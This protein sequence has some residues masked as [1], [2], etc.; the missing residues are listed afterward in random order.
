MRIDPG[1]ALTN[2]FLIIGDAADEQAGESLPNRRTICY[3]FFCRS[4]AQSF[5]SGTFGEVQEG[6]CA[7]GR[8]IFSPLRAENHI[9]L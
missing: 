8:A 5:W 3:H 9:A 2:A 4:R 1:E 6:P 7:A